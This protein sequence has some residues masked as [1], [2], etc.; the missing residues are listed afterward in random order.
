MAGQSTASGSMPDELSPRHIARR[1]LAL[2]LV[3][4]LVAVAV[5]S[6]PG[7]GELRARFAEV[8]PLLLALIG[9][10]KL[11]SSLSNVVAFREVFCRRMSRRFSYEL[12]MAEQATNVLLPT[13][14]AARRSGPGGPNYR[15]R[16]VTRIVV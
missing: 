1:L 3:I 6:L 9:L 12:G 2:G 4:A 7:L 11:C 10:M 13:G 8:N 15:R 16:L 14:G 5:S